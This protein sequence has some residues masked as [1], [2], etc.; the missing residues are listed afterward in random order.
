MK[1]EWDSSEDVGAGVMFIAT[2]GGAML[3]ARNYPFGTTLNM[4]PGYFPTVLG[5]LLAILGAVIL[6]KG[7]RKK[8]RMQSGWSVR[9]LIV[10]PLAVVAFGILMKLAGFIPALAT[11]VFLSA[12]AGREFRLM[13]VVL[14]AAFLTALSVGLFIW[15]LGLPYPLIKMP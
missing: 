15:G 6:L 8:V 9:A 11:L 13:E 4:G 3:I 10:L 1:L 12:A 14:L 5:G 2:G 7:L